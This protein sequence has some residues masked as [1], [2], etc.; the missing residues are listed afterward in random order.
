M[1]FMEEEL[2]IFLEGSIS[3]SNANASEPNNQKSTSKQLSSSKWNR[4]ESKQ[5]AS[6]DPE[7]KI[8]A[9]EELFPA[10]SDEAISRMK[11]IASLM[12]SAGYG[13]ECCQVYSTLRRKAFKEAMKQQGFEKISMDEVQKMQWEALEGHMATWIKVVKYSAK[14]ILPGETKLCCSIFCDFP[15]IGEEMSTN[16]ATAVIL[17]F[18]NFAEAIAMTKRSAERLFKVLD[19]Y[20]TLTE[21]ISAFDDSLYSKECADA[22]RSD[23][24]AVRRRLGEAAVCIF[25]DL[26]NSIRSDVAGN[27]VPTGSVHPLTRYT[28]NYLRYACDFKDALDQV[29][30]QHHQRSEQSKEYLLATGEKAE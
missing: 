22:L 7:T 17:L 19:I 8:T 14:V 26:E 11:N 30:S 29:F 18:L 4:Q 13:T 20:E 9:E 12:I 16:L 25:Y 5:N 6:K 21:L 27:P 23:I 1:M 15:S 28:M 24:S 3:S 2:Q 10:I